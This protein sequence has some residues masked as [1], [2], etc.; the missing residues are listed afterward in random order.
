[1][2]KS[3]SR[4]RVRVGI[5]L[6]AVSLLLAV[7]L[8]SALPVV[9]DL[10]PAL[11]LVGAAAAL[12]LAGARSQATTRLGR[13]LLIVL[14]ALAGLASLW[15]AR[16]LWLLYRTEEVRFAGDQGVELTGTLYLPRSSGRRAAVVLVHGSGREPRREYRFYA[17]RFARAGLIA[18]AYDKRGSG[19]SSGDLRTASYEQLAADAVGAVEMLRSRPEVDATRVGIWGVSEGEWV[20][21]LAAA[22]SKPAFLVVVSPSAMTASAQVRYETRANVLRAGFGEAAANRAADLYTRL[23][24]FQRT[25]AGREELNRLLAAAKSENWFDAAWY[26]EESVPEYDRVLALDWFPAWRNRM[27]FDALPLL[28]ELDCPVLA[29]VGG[30]DPKNDGQAALDRLRAAVARRGTSRFTGRLYPSAGH[31]MI[32]WPLPGRLPPPWFAKGYLRDQLA[33]VLHS[34]SARQ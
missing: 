4:W 18:L 28:G 15:A 25:G 22:R 30:D 7:L 24:E 3:P 11:V 31:G 23:S 19:A 5:A 13:G 21:S 29:Q 32:V 20:G 6:A 12:V 2:A 16:D 17:R 33:W 27:D 9:L 8:T 10:R 14:A 26:L 34:A 1:M